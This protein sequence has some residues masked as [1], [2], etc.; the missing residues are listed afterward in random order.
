MLKVKNQDVVYKVLSCIFAVILIV[1][2]VISRNIIDLIYLG[3][4]SIFILRYFIEIK[5]KW[6]YYI[7]SMIFYLEVWY[8]YRYALS[9][10]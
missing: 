8:V 5:R 10:I 4:V 6:L 2:I 1:V 9:F 3:I 7:Y